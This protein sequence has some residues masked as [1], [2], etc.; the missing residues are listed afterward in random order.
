M[1]VVLCL[2]IYS[3]GGAA[4]GRLGHGSRLLEDIYSPLEIKCLSSHSDIITT[5]K[6]TSSLPI[7]DYYNIT[8]TNIA[9]TSLSCGAF[10]SAAITNNGIVFTWGLGMNGRLGRINI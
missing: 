4:H 7:K 6:S 8:S 5:I 2:Q 10:H 9:V 3:W 1:Y